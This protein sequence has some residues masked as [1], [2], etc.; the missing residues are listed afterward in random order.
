MLLTD[1]FKNNCKDELEQIKLD[2][3]ELVRLTLEHVKEKKQLP[4]EVVIQT[5]SG[6]KPSRGLKENFDKKFVKNSN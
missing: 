2:N 3:F 6:R 1:S 5:P 4:S